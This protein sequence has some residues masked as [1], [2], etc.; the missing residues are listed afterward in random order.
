MFVFAEVPGKYTGL[1]MLF[2]FCTVWCSIE[3]FRSRGVMQRVSA[4]LHLLMAVVMTLMVPRELWVPLR[5]LVGIPALV[6]LFA[7]ATAWF[8][9]AA[10]RPASAGTPARRHFAGHAAMFA[11]MTWHLAAMMVKHQGMAAGS[12]AGMGA[13]AVPSAVQG[14][15]FW[16]AVAGVPFMVYLAVAGIAELVR[17]VAPARPTTPSAAHAGRVAAGTRAE[18]TTL[19][20]ARPLTEAACY[21]P[22]P[23]GAALRLHHLNGAAMNLGMFWMS[24]GLLVPIAPFL[25]VF[26]F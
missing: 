12:G 20:A 11:A 8:V 22:A 25:A 16:A 2:V 24:T 26:A 13:P 4:G 6:A 5:T 19:V 9:V 18:G 14:P 10:A 21:A 1:L 15:V 23:G 7:A 17:A 3:L